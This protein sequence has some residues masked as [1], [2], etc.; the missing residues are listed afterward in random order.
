MNP[1]DAPPTSR[2]AILV[3]DAAVGA[4]LLAAATARMV[5]RRARGVVKP[6][7]VVFLRPPMLTERYQAGTYLDALARQGVRGRGEVER[8]VSA[9][10]DKMVPPLVAAVV[11]RIDLG[12]LAEG[13]IA[14]IDLA[15]II[16]QSTGSVASETVRGVRMQS[17]SGDE[18]VG[19]AVGR[20]RVRFSRKA[21]PK[22][23]TAEQ[24]PAEPA[25]AAE[26]EMTA[27]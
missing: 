20:L 13:V 5:G 11:Q 23:P 12:Q 9:L 7:A 3:L 18:A 21:T 10:L 6:V 25:S 17:I 26:P 4:T 22:P 15:E 27:T 19:N 1:P 2:D 24:P 8:Q 16:R 14:E